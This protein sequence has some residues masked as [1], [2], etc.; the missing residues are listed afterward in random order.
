MRVL[1]TSTS[2][3]GHLHPLLPLA[4]AAQAAG[5]EVLVAGGG[6]TLATVSDLGFAAVETAEPSPADSGRFWAGLPAQAEPNTYVIADFFARL[7]ARA[8]LPATRGLVADWRP[9]LV[10]SEVAEFAGQL[11]AEEAGL[12]HVTVGIAS[13]GL[14]DLTHAAVAAAVDELRGELGLPV[15]GTVP[16]K[17]PTTRFVTALPRLLWRSA[18][19]VP[20]DTRVYR[21]EDPEGPVPEPAAVPRSRSGRPTVY[22]SLGSVAGS[23]PFAAPAYGAVLAGLGA[24]D[25]DVLFT[26][27]AMDRAALGPVPANVHVESYVP[28]AVAMSCDVV[29]THGGSGTTTAAL[30]R[31]LPM[32]VVPLFADQMHNADRVAAAGVGLVVDGRRA[33]TDLA[34]AVRRVLAE[35]SFAR[36]AQDVAVELR[37]LPSAG[38]VLAA[39]RPAGIH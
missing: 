2:G 36:A 4:R 6:D 14:P 1:V 38:E 26:V 19:D 21:H 18:D 5:D 31:G 37:A 13:M 20:A 35:E 3:L 39:V 17:L 9:D 24:L 29:V 8:A 28:Q 32:V 16:W 33:A 23:M 30:T 25:A 15:D 7:R 27:G 12:P 10:V 34:P 11:A 22:A